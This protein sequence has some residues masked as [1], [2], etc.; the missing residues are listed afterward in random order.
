MS[1]EIYALA[2]E[3][4]AKRVGV[5]IRLCSGAGVALATFFEGAEVEDRAVGFHPLIPQPDA[6]VGFDDVNPAL[7]EVGRWDRTAERFVPE[8]RMDERMPIAHLGSFWID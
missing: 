8:I 5:A 6:R 2:K 4:T 3:I 1:R 7:F